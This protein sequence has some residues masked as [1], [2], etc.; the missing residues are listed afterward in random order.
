MLDGS[1]DLFKRECLPLLWRDSDKVRLKVDSNVVNAIQAL[2]G[3]LDA[4][5]S[6]ASLKSLREDSHLLEA[7]VLQQRHAR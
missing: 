6:R 7:R 1:W 2:K 3:V 4:P 5:P